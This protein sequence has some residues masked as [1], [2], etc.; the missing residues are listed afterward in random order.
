MRHRSARD[1]LG[2]EEWQGKK[3]ESEWGIFVIV[4]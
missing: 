2:E 1:G 3:E 4:N